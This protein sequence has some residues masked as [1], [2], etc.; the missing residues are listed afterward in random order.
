MTREGVACAPRQHACAGN[1]F[2]LV[3]VG[4]GRRP[5]AEGATRAARGL[6]LFA[7]RVGE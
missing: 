2:L 3:T 6:S 5:C 4:E 1:V 7:H